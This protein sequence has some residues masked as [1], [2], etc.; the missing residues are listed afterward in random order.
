[1]D[2]VEADVYD[3]VSVLGAGGFD[4]VFTGMGALTWIPS[5]KRWAET[6]AG[7]L[8][9]GGRL[10]IR[11]THPMLWA[12]EGHPDGT[13]TVDHAYFEVD[14]PFVMTNASTY[15]DRN[16]VLE[17]Q[18]THEW[19]HGLGEI[20]AALLA[21]G[22]RITAIEEH[23]SVPYEAFAGLME[24]TRFGEYRLKDRPERVPH[25]YT[26]QAVKE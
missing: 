6:V 13:L 1:V 10:F 12:L 23:D 8:K 20:I 4:L 7:L 19:N 5:I 17:N 3:A 9:P 24:K 11:E 25:S 16:E 22:M 21:E 18:T 15:V 26:L 14:E 2:F